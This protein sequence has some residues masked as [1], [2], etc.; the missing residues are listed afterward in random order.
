VASAVGKLIDE[1]WSIS[2][3]IQ[4]AVPFLVFCEG[5]LWVNFDRIEVQPVDCPLSLVEWPLCSGRYIGFGVD[6]GPS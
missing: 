5:P 3:P 2:E 4:A 6:T 1:A